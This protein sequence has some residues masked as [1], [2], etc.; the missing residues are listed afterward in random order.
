MGQLAV[1]LP[2]LYPHTG[3]LW[4]HFAMAVLAHAAAGAIAEVLRTVHGAGHARAVEDTLAAHL[5]IEE[6]ALGQFFAPDENAACPAGI[7]ASD[8]RVEKT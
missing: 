2:G 1:P 5:A 7:E 3:H 6:V 4:D 8:E